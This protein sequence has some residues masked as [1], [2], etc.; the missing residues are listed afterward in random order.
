MTFMFYST[1]SK[2]GDKE[3]SA[4]SVLYLYSLTGEFRLQDICFK[5]Q[6]EAQSSE[7]MKGGTQQN[8]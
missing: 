2:H 8:V 5:G 3:E 7:V 6:K 4:G 1:P